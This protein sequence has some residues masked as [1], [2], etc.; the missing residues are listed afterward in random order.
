[1]SVTTPQLL[2]AAP[3]AASGYSAPGVVYNSLGKFASTTQLNADVPLDNLFPDLT[4]PQNA[5]QQV[6]YQ[7]LFFYNA[8]TTFTLTNVTAWLPQS[9][10]QTTAVDWAV[11]ADTTLPSLFTSSTPQAGLITSPLIAPST[12]TG[13][14]PPVENLPGGASLGS[15]APSHVAAF[16]IRRT[17]TGFTD[18]SGDPV[19]AGF[20]IQVTFD[21]TMTS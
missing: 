1:M 2:L 6:D 7:A 9:A 4:G 5:A 19:L 17:A 12:V 14:E 10:V 15:I 21:V 18:E 13:F 16:W 11:G 8:D 3:A 20:N